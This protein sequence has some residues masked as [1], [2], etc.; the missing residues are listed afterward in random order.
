MIVSMAVKLAGAN[1]ECYCAPEIQARVRV[2]RYSEFGA[3]SMM[4]LQLAA[5]CKVMIS[6][7]INNTNPTLE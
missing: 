3:S 7:V 2:Q 4:I 6:K 5:R 1:G